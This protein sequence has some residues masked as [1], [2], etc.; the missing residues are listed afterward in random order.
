[1]SKTMENLIREKEMNDK[2]L[3][4]EAD[5]FN[6]DEVDDDEERDKKEEDERIMEDSRQDYEDRMLGM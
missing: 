2:V 4:E 5:Y 1:M 3:L 6:S